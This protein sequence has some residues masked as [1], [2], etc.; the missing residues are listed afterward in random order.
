MHTEKHCKQVKN[1]SGSGFTLPEFIMAVLAGSLLITGSGVALRSMSGVISNSAEKANARQNSVNGIKLLRSEVERSMNLL[2]FG[3]TPS[4]LPDTDLA[5]HISNLEGPITPDDGIVSYCENKATNEGRYFK[6]VFGIKMVEL[7]NPVIY[8]L[9]TNY[10]RTYGGDSYGY[11]LVRCGVPLDINGQYDKEASPYISLVLDDIAP[12]P[13]LKN[14]NSCEEIKTID[15][16]TKEE[17]MK[18]KTKILADLN[19][20]FIPTDDSTSEPDAFTA[21]RTFQ[22]PAIRFKTDHNRK[23]LA[24]EDPALSTDEEDPDNL[25]DMSFL[26]TRNSSQK[27][28]MTAFARADKRLV[29]KNLNGLTLNGVYF[30]AKIGNTVRFVVDASGSMRECMVTTNNICK[31]TRMASVKNELIQILTDLKN[32]APYTKVG[33]E[34]FSHKGGENHRKWSFDQANDG[35]P[36]ELVEIGSD[37]ALADAEAMIQSIKPSGFT[38]PWNGLDAAFADH[39]TTTV[40]L[41]SDGV[42]MFKE[43]SYQQWPNERRDI[44]EDLY[45]HWDQTTNADKNCKEEVK[46]VQVK[47]WWGWGWQWR[48]EER[49][50]DRCSWSSIASFYI[51]KNS[52][53]PSYRQ[54][55]VHTVSID[56]KSDWMEKLS[57]ETGGSH[58][59]VNSEN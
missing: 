55:K 27:I 47:Y 22:E 36:E 49:I 45:A 48:W 51:N 12:I 39:E 3:E 23:V 4:H 52:E 19:V 24:F 1:H 15:E 10:S 42:P 37:G 9:S 26:A 18:L 31:K 16:A 38:E 32:I 59:Q 21:Y 8:G 13:C 30:N 28:Y 29:R 5:N 53:R 54:L 2:V 14:K 7:A 57:Q 35:L 46:W 56:L 33:I 11:A 50:I 44:Y 20:D 6:A 40:F 58:N 43:G 17:R 25:L 41:L 34:F